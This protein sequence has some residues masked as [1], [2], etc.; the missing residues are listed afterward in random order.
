[1]AELNTRGNM[2]STLVNDNPSARFIC[3]A[4]LI[5]GSFLV[6]LAYPIILLMTPASGTIKIATTIA[7]WALSWAVFSAGIFLIGPEGYRRFKAFWS[8]NKSGST[9]D[10]KI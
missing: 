6:Y 3:G 10:K 8:R 1:M 5:A 7:L 2:D 9:V 4:I